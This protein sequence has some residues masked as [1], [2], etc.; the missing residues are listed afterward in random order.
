M[1]VTVDGKYYEI[2]MSWIAYKV[3]LASASLWAKVTVH[4]ATDI[5]FF[6]LFYEHF[7]GDYHGS[8]QGFLNLGAMVYEVLSYN[9]GNGTHRFPPILNFTVDHEFGIQH[10]K[11]QSQCA[12]FV[13]GANVAT[14][15]SPFI[16]SQPFDIESAEVNGKQGTLFEKF[17]PGIKLP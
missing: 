10:K 4:S 9:N 6:P 16:S 15:P 5:P 17:P 3:A 13:D 14:N 11:D 2:A 7:K 1:T 12:F 8:F